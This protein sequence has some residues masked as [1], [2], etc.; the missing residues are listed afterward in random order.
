MSNFYKISTLFILILLAGA[1]CKKKDDDGGMVD[2]KAENRKVLG[3]SAEDILSADTYTKMRV[4]LVFTEFSRPT[5][6]TIDALVPFLNERVNKP[7][8]ITIT[9]K[10]IPPPTTQPYSLDDI[11]EIED[12]HRTQ[13]TID[14]DIA[15][16][17]FF[18]DGGSENDT[19]TSFTLGSAYQNTSL[20]VYRNTLFNFVGGPN[21]V[22]ITDLETITAEHE[23]GHLFGLVNISND[24]IHNSGH[25]DPENDKHCVIEDCIMYFSSSAGREAIEA[26]F[27]NRTPGN[28]P[29]FDDLC[30]ADLQAKGGK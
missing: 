3:A 30:L 15:V 5:S 10:V 8:G 17:I 7:G 22:T 11:R 14:D 9:Q 13:Y 20:V 4:E 23:F 6:E 28:I 26:R 21:D 29:V 25:I 24:D 16:Y 18:A 1:S 2:P 27:Q 12:E 19:E